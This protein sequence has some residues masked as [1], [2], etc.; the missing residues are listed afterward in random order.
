[1]DLAHRFGR[2]AD[3]R[4]I[5]G[6]IPALPEIRLDWRKAR[7]LSWVLLSI[8]LGLIGYGIARNEAR[9]AWEQAHLPGERVWE[10]S[11]SAVGVHEV[12]DPSSLQKAARLLPS[13][14]DA[15]GSVWISESPL[16]IAVGGPQGFRFF[17]AAREGA[18]RG[19]LRQYPPTLW[20]P[21]GRSWEGLELALSRIEKRPAAG[22]IPEKSGKTAE[23]LDSREIRY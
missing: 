10:R 22:S 12:R 11:L 23:P 2:I 21:L 15:S 8:P 13:M 16:W 18:G 17:A 20:Q 6:R 4:R 7:A 3:L 5:S 14:L 1:M 9:L 19:R